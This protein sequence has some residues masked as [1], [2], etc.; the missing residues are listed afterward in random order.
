ML[1]I[2]SYPSLSITI[3]TRQAVASKDAH[4]PALI[5]PFNL[6]AKSTRVL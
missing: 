6:G 1:N 5:Y 3:H 4:R 2:A